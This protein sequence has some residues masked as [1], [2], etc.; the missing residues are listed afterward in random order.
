[1]GV[2]RV[3]KRGT[4]IEV[5][6]KDVIRDVIGKNVI[7]GIKDLGINTKSIKDIK[8]FQIYRFEKNVS[9]DKLREIAEKILCDPVTQIFELKN[10]KGKVGKKQKN[11]F[12]VYI[13]FK[14]GV[15][16]SVADSLKKA[17]C[18]LGV[19]IGEVATGR[20]FLINARLSK[21]QVNFIISKLLANKIVEYWQ[22]LQ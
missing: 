1:M 17:A 7:S 22:I 13:W 8:S 20:K 5:G 10:A 6:Y 16:D 14:K 15:T 3:E 2:K 18:D 12:E 19:Y 4:I 21:V 11:Y 9:V